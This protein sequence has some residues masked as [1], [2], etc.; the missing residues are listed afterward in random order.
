MFSDG[1]HATVAQVVDIIHIRLVVDQ[2]N[3]ITDNGDDVLI[4]QHTRL[5]RNIEIQFLIDTVTTNL[6]KVVTLIRE[7]KFVQSGTCCLLIRSSRALQLQIDILNSLFARVCRVFLQSI[8]NHGVVRVL[9][10]CLMEEYG[11]DISIR[12]HLD[13]LF[14]EYCLAVDDD[15]GTLD[16][17][18]LT[19][20]VVHKILI[21]GFGDGCGKFLSQIFLQVRFGGLDLV[22]D[23]ENAQDVLVGLITDG[24]KQS[25]NR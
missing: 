5:H 13:V 24:A 11:F 14:L 12:N 7:E 21:P 10:V 3:Q 17:H 9:L 16:I 19:G 20:L 8:E 25:G 22:S 23:I 2:L 6:P 4:G 1:T 18:H 15:L